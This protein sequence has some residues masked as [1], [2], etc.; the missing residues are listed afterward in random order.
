MH[1]KSSGLLDYLGRDEINANK[2]QNTNTKP[3]HMNSVEKPVSAVV[4]WSNTLCSTFAL[5]AL[6]QTNI[7]RYSILKHID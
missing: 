4:T 5:P 3:N 2:K 6:Y 7:L 1:T